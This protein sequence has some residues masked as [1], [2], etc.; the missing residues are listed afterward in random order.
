MG[1]LK[2]LVVEGNTKEENVNF[3]QAGCASQSENFS[4][5]IKMHEPDCE[6]DIIEPAD[7]SS[8]EKIISS[9]KKY[10]GVILTGS[11]LRINDNSE[12]VKKHIEFTRRCFEHTNYIYAACWGL[13]VSV[14]AAG[15]KCRVATN[16]ANTGIAQDVMLTDVGIKHRLYKSKPKKFNAPAF[17]FDEVEIPPKNSVLLASTSVNKFSAIHFTA[18]KS[19]VWGLQY[20]PEIPYSYMI[21]LLKHRKKRLIDN[22]NFENE[23]ELN[24]YIDLI[25]KEDLI[26]NDNSR[27][28]ELKNW[29]DHIKESK[30]SVSIG[31][32]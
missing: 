18:G 22:K 23:N 19:E 26:T 24:K 1:K 27:T 4:E 29:L 13:Q 8:M 3:D 14:A 17:N 20:H 12:E 9:L 21:R 6:V 11:T 30:F 15:G 31:K 2:I 7:N 16:G 32:L 25:T 5:H 28:L 10:N